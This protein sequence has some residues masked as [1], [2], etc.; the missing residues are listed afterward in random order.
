MIEL[1]PDPVEPRVQPAPRAYRYLDFIGVAFVTILLCAN[2]MAGKAC[3]IGHFSFGGSII[4][5]P[6]S[7]LFGD[8]L[9][10]VYGYARSRKVVWAGFGALIFA[11]IMAWLI[12]HLPPDP[13]WHNQHA[14]ETI[15]GSTWRITLGSLLAY[16]WG[17]LS[18]SFTLA[19]MKIF[20]NG[21]HMWSRFLGSTVVGE[22]VDTLICYPI[23]FI[24]VWPTA[25]VLHVM[26]NNYVLKVLWEL[27]MLP[28]TY[29]VVNFLK[30][31]E[32]EDYFDR[33][34]NFTPFSID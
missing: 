12:V 6:L 11:T 27:L 20:T 17:E 22:A 33:H 7:Y 32:R 19:K 34:T 15:F 23:A 4:F 10:E 31:A 21:S 24:G 3:A 9:T 29:R 2:L 1:A 18:N 13:T 8:I 26:V 28:F 30:Q 25:L 14:Y 16:F 5:F